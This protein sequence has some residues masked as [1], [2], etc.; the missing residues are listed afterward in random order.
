MAHA[1]EADVV[2]VL[3]VDDVAAA[4]QVALELALDTCEL[5]RNVAHLYAD[6]SEPTIRFAADGSHDLGNAVSSI[7][8]ASGR[9]IR[10]ASGGLTR[11]QVAS[12]VD[13]VRPMVDHLVL[14]GPDVALTQLSLEFATL[15]DSAVIVGGNA[16][17]VARLT[18]IL[19]QLGVPHRV[20]SSTQGPVEIDTS[21]PDNPTRRITPPGRV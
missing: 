5:G 9:L 12:I 4:H 7:P 11:L 17:E 6:L 1:G 13:Q 18:S 2:T 21:P 15:A 8:T 3:A 16:A 20:S 10:I 19:D 14:S